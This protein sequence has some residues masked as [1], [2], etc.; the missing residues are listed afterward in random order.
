MPSKNS[1]TFPESEPSAGSSI[2]T[3]GRGGLLLVLG[4]VEAADPQRRP[5]LQGKHPTQ[6]PDN[7]NCRTR[8]V[9]G[10]DFFLK[11]FKIYFWP[12]WVFVA[13]CGLS[14]VVVSG[15]LIAMAS[16]AAEHRPQ[17]TGFSS[18]SS[19]SVVMAPRL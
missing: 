15:L 5:Y 12:C 14:L 11:V 3:E 17:T 13:V 19:G 2:D 8:Q 6:G 16:A 18:W 4:L 7:P 10:E 1:C 9:S